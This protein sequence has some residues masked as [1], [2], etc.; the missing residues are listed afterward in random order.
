MVDAF[1]RQ[2]RSL[3][4]ECKTPPTEILKCTLQMLCDELAREIDAHWSMG[5]ATIVLS[6]ALADYCDSRWEDR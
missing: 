5:P 2:F 1:M 6:N 4:V 3:Q